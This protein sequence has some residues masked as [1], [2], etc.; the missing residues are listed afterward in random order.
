MYFMHALRWARGHWPLLKSVKPFFFFFL[1]NRKFMVKLWRTTSMVSASASK[2]TK[3]ATSV[4]AMR[5]TER[6]PFKGSTLK[7]QKRR[8]T[9]AEQPLHPGLI[10]TKLTRVVVVQKLMND[11]RFNQHQA[12]GYKSMMERVSFFCVSKDALRNLKGRG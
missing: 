8:E 7:V 4:L 11:S 1:K 2:A 12:E 10:S 9:A 6:D 3:F 5:Q